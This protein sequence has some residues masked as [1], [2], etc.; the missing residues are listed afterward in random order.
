[1]YFGFTGVTFKYPF[2]ATPEPPGTF[3]LAKRGFVYF[4]KRVNGLAV[5]LENDGRKLTRPVVVTIG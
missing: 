2:P 5:L 3:A 1:M 4:V